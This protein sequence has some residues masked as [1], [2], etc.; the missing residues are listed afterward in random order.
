MRCKWELVSLDLAEWL[1]EKFAQHPIFNTQEF[2]A[3]ILFR[4][5][6]YSKQK[7]RRSLFLNDL[8]F[9]IQER[10]EGKKS[11][12]TDCLQNGLP[13]QCQNCNI[14]IML[15]PDTRFG[16]RESHTHFDARCFFFCFHRMQ[17]SGTWLERWKSPKSHRM[18]YE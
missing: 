1:S 8:N 2:E 11:N 6:V 15:L 9:Q 18:S 3:N 13:L 7:S 10:K 17:T 4:Q 14:W 12:R 16:K 5:F